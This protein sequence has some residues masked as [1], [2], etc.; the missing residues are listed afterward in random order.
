MKHIKKYNE[1]SSKN[2]LDFE[3]LNDVFAELRDDG[4]FS[5]N[6]YSIMINKPEIDTYSNP[7]RKSTRPINI[8]NEI[9]SEAEK[10]I[11]ILQDIEVC[12]VRIF[13]KYPEY[14]LYTK[15]E[16]EKDY[17]SIKIHIRQQ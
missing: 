5:Q 7:S 10:L 12:L 8:V 6:Y 13:E 3:F 2:E 1:S 4:A 9:K 17:I 16:N 15:L 14:E 11:K